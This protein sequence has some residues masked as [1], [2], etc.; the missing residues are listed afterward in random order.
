MATAQN[1]PTLIEMLKNNNIEAAAVGGWNGT[2]CNFVLR[3]NGALA[4]YDPLTN[5]ASAAFC[6]SS[7]AQPCLPRPRP[8]IHR[9]CM[10][11]SNYFEEKGDS[12]GS[13]GS[14]GNGASASEGIRI[15][16]SS[17][18]VQIQR[19]I[20][21]P[22][23]IQ[24]N[25]PETGNHDERN[26]GDREYS[27]TN[28][29]YYGR[30]PFGPCRPF[31]P[32]PYNRKHPGILEKVLQCGPGERLIGGASYYDPCQNKG[33]YINCTK[34]PC[35]PYGPYYGGRGSGFKDSSCPLFNT[36][37]CPLFKGSGNYP[38]NGYGPSFGNSG[39]GCYPYYGKGY[40]GYGKG[41]G[42][43][44]GG[45]GSG[46]YSGYG[47]GGYNG[48]RSGGP[49]SGDYNGYGSGDPGSG[50]STGYENGYGGGGS[51][52]YSG[53]GG[54]SNEGNGNEGEGLG[55]F[56]A[57][58]FPEQG[59]EWYA[60]VSQGPQ[61]GQSPFSRDIPMG[62]HNEPQVDQSPF[63]R[64]MTMADQDEPLGETAQQMEGNPMGGN[65]QGDEQE[66]ERPPQMDEGEQD[67][68][69]ESER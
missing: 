16:Q 15:I 55:G 57:D 33:G 30:G 28:N 19:D 5:N 21:F 31:Y 46:G 10:R 2:P 50:G 7:E 51:N 63:S 68:L 54:F 47:S 52:G 23:D 40:D 11:P 48:Y 3:N 18:P 1:L 60:G 43:Y 22:R 8:Q 32:R 25:I 41:Y 35:Y 62:D 59:P 45:Y 42:P 36:L 17:Q 12:K 64:N 24:I 67:Q 38:Y 9:V 20:E 69:E 49:G 58:D 13:N 26:R 29:Y 34:A 53:Y 61:G 37:S 27:I 39:Y 44:Y 6:Y 66:P 56:G 14:F 65:G 4:P